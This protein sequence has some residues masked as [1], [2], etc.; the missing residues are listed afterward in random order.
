MRRSLRFY[1]NNEREVMK[2]L[3]FKPTKNSGSGWV[4]KEDGENEIA[5]CQLKSTDA[6]SISIKQKDLHVLD[7][8]ASI[9]HK[10]PVFAIQFLNTGEVWLLCKPKDIEILESER[11]KGI[12]EEENEDFSEKT[13]DKNTKKM[14]TK[15]ELKE[16]A[17]ARQEFQKALEEARQKREQEV[18]ERRKRKFWKKNTGSEE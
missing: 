8:H 4:E 18:K 15:G 16:K 14:Y 5:I 13:I 7:Y 1:R 11:I 10:V 6:Q 2:A 17:K 9:S 12:F 3:G